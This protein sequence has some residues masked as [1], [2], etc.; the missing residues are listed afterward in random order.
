MSMKKKNLELFVIIDDKE[1]YQEA[2]EFIEAV[3]PD[4]KPLVLLI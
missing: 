3:I 1:I 2:R 4:K